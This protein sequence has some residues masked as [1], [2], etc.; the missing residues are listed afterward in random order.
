VTLVCTV[1]DE[2]VENE[3]D[4]HD[5]SEL[6]NSCF[7]VSGGSMYCCGIMY[8]NGEDTCSSCGDPL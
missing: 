8:D 1:C 7:E 6:C 4:W 3:A 5:E 2:V